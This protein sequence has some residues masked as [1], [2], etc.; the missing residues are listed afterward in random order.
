M[1]FDIW[2]C[3]IRRW[4]LFSYHSQPMKRLYRKVL[5][6]IACIPLVTFRRDGSKS[7]IHVRTAPALDEMD[8]R[9]VPSYWGIKHRFV[10][11]GKNLRSNMSHFHPTDPI[12]FN[13]QD[14]VSAFDSLIPLR[15]II[16]FSTLG[17]TLCSF[18]EEPY[19]L[20]AE[21]IFYKNK[22]INNGNILSG[23]NKHLS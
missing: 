21:S 9:A 11:L 2:N 23:K 7:I 15:L 1:C 10:R 17:V 6:W 16:D 5:I 3:N 14:P 18:S 4:L 20:S 12:S 19:E 8:T 13:L 22:S